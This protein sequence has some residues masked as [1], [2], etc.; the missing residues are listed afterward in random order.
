MNVVLIIGIKNPITRV[1]VLQPVS[2]VSNLPKW[3]VCHRGRIVIS[4][5]A[6]HEPINLGISAWY[7]S[8]PRLMLIDATG[9]HVCLML[10]IWLLIHHNVL[11]RSNNRCM[12]MRLQCNMYLSAAQLQESIVYSILLNF[13]LQLLETN[14]KYKSNPQYQQTKHCE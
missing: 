10:N 9:I 14:W 5:R 8:H 7:C 13:I 1:S 11:P 12:L 3:L 4:V 6:D 2:M